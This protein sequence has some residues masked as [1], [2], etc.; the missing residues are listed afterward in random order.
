MLCCTDMHHDIIL[1]CIELH[2]SHGLAFIANWWL[3]SGSRRPPEVYQERWCVILFLPR[4]KRGGFARVNLRVF[5]PCRQSKDFSLLTGSKK[6]VKP[7]LCFGAR[8]FPKHINL[9]W[10]ALSVNWR[11]LPFLWAHL[12]ALV[13]AINLLCPVLIGCSHSELVLRRVKFHS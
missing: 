4:S 8:A 5:L 11:C 9:I 2:F 10:S 12:K 7:Y 13:N 3:R 6:Q 1:C